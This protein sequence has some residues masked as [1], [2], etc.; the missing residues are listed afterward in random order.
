MQ[1]YN[2]SILNA[3]RGVTELLGI[4]KSLKI[5]FFHK[6]YTFSTYGVHKSYSFYIN[7]D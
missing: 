6:S 1:Q 3:I 2:V 5:Q 7:L 4:H